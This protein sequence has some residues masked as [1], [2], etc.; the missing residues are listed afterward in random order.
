MRRFT[1]EPIDNGWFLKL[2]EPSQ[3]KLVGRYAYADLQQAL[4]A[5]KFFVSQDSRHKEEKK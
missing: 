5:I 2:S 4:D 1:L 3:D